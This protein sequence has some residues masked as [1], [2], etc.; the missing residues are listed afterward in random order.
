MKKSNIVL[1]DYDVLLHEYSIWTSARASQRGFCSTRDIAES[2][3]ASGLQS[4]A[5][6]LM[7]RR[8]IDFSAYHK[9][10]CDEL[11]AFLGNRIHK[12]V[13]WG[14]IAKI[15]NVYLKT[16]VVIPGKGSANKHIHPPIDGRLLDRL[17][18]EKII[19]NKP[20][21]WSKMS[22]NEYNA[23]IKSLYADDRF[24]QLWMYDRLW[25]SYKK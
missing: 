8:E 20:K 7:S 15:V 6:T 2:I 23:L 13:R 22:E 16:S 17:K 21:A 25:T 18:K 1:S 24:E 4:F 12:G 3:N 11:L 10:V 5:K 14:R 9:I 19:V